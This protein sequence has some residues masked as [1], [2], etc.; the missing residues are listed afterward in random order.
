MGNEIYIRFELSQKKKDLRKVNPVRMEML[1]EKLL[2]FIVLKSLTETNGAPDSLI[3]GGINPINKDLS[4]QTI[5]NFMSNVDLPYSEKES[6]CS[7]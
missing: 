2:A 6:Y 7:K 5:S 4:V 1:E 3:I